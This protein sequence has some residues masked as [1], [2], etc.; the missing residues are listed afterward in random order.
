MELHDI[1]LAMPS[2]WRYFWCG[3]DICGCLGCANASGGVRA[4]G[5]TQEDWQQWV[6]K[7]PNPDPLSQSPYIHPDIKK[8]LKDI[9]PYG[10]ITKCKDETNF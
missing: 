8:Y 4:A 2:H 7:N 6:D 9:P 5:F 10:D 3:A 1:M